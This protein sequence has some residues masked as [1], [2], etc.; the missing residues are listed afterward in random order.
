MSIILMVIMVIMVIYDI[1]N[2][3]QYKFHLRYSFGSIKYLNYGNTK[4]LNYKN[5]KCPILQNYSMIF[6][7]K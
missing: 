7:L 6:F 5:A 1:Y 2:N 4:Y 3:R